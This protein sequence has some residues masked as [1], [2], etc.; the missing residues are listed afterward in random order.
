MK[1][2][3][4]CA[5]L[6]FGMLGCATSSGLNTTVSSSDFDNSKTIDIAPHGLSCKKTLP[7]CP[8]VGFRWSDKTPD[9]AY[10]R[11]AVYDLSSVNTVGGN[12]LS[13]KD[14]RLKINGEV[15]TL[16]PVGNGL[17]NYSYDKTVGKTSVQVYEVPISLLKN[18]YSS[19]ETLVQIVTD[20]RNLEDYFVK[21][22]A[23]TKA[24]HA[25][26]RFLETLSPQ[27]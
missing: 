20:K 26:G 11:L 17:T 14:L 12:Y 19:K 1:R 27:R 8:S 9:N 25:L 6:S 5:A 18:I 16:K 21:S 3:L 24:Y 10:I 22:D 2:L 15:V 23:D 4:L 7:Y 13:I